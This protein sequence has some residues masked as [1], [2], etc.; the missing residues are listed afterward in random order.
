MIYARHS[1][2]EG[3]SIAVILDTIAR[4]SQEAAKLDYLVLTDDIGQRLQLERLRAIKMHCANRRT[5][6]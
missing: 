3:L 1:S 5:S 2:K 4:W 6:N